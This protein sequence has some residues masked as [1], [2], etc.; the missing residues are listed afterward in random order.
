MTDVKDEGR[1]TPRSPLIQ[2]PVLACAPDS[3][4]PSPTRTMLLPRT[5]PP[6]QVVTG[7][8]PKPPPAPDD[9]IDLALDRDIVESLKEEIQLAAGL[10]LKSVDKFSLHRFRSHQVSARKSMKEMKWKSPKKR[11]LEEYHEKE[12]RYGLGRTGSASPT[13]HLST[14]L[15]KEV[16][17]P[18]RLVPSKPSILMKKRSKRRAESVSDLPAPEPAHSRHRSGPSSP[19]K[20]RRSPAALYS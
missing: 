11:D 18:F 17:E 15:P 6:L 5:Y 10:A 3:P 12:Q 20:G 14:T 7:L 13:G 19:Q 8:T 9:E 4:P 1:L 16:S 2:I